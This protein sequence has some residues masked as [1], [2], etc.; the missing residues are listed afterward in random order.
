[1]GEKGRVLEP[2]P[3]SAVFG[4]AAR[5][6]TIALEAAPT[7]PAVLVYA[8]LAAAIAGGKPRPTGRV[9]HRCPQE[10]GAACN[11]EP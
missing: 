7:A 5:N 4:H 3:E 2:V 6:G 8:R 11:G 9:V 10:Q 1:M